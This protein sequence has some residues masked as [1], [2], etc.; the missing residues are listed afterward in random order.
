MALLPGVRARA[1]RADRGARP[2]A[3]RVRERA[4]RLLREPGRDHDGVR[5]GGRGLPHP[6]A[7]PRA[8]APRLGPA[9]RIRRGRRAPDRDRAARGV[10]GD[11][12]RGRCRAGSSGSTTASTATPAGPRWT[13][14][15]CAGSAAATSGSGPSTW[16]RAGIRST[17]SPTRRS[18]PSARH[19]KIFGGAWADWIRVGWSPTQEVTH[20]RPRA[21]HRMGRRCARAGGQEPRRVRRG[22]RAL[23]EASGRRPHRELRR[24]APRAPR[25][26][27]RGLRAHPR[28]ARADG[29]RCRPTPSSGAP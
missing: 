25:R 27:P 11:R 18:R 14:P 19:S 6:P 22:R 5:A 10:R 12:P 8:A 17:A 16:T 13:S 15:T 28:H 3:R 1:R 9:R 26:G 7:R 23:R 20:G 24:G 21:V 2:R 4:L 29:R